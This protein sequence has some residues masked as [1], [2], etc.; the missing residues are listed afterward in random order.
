LVDKA[1]KICFDGSRTDVMRHI[2]DE[3]GE[4]FRGW[5]NRKIVKANKGQIRITCGT[6]AFAGGEI[7]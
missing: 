7:N 5:F 4:G 1:R 3:E 6:I 2:H